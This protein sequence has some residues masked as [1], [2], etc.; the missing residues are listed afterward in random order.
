MP[1]YLQEYNQSVVRGTWLAM[2][3]L[4]PTVASID[5]TSNEF[6]EKTLPYQQWEVSR[7]M[8]YID[9]DYKCL[10]ELDGS[11]AI[12]IITPRD[13]GPVMPLHMAGEA[14]TPR[15]K[16]TF[17]H[18]PPSAADRRSAGGTTGSPLRT[19]GSHAC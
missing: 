10:H 9:F 1:A 13:A 6:R 2:E 19:T 14:D 8:N 4:L 16:H 5:V 18:W 15:S 11:P 3:N 7:S 17:R 12:L